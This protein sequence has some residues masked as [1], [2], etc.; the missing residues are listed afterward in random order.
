MAEM[1]ETEM[2]YTASGARRTGDEY[3]DLQS[4]EV[5]IQWL[6]QPDVYRWVRLETMEGSLDDIQ[7]EHADGARRL[8]QVKFGTDATV[9]W[10][11]DDLIK[12][13][14]GRRGPK[15]SLL[16]K[17][18]NSLDD[19]RASGA[20]VSEAALLTNRAASP[21]I[22]AHLSDSGL[23]NFDSLS[24]T[25][26]ATLSAQLGGESAA[27]LFF[28]SFHFFFK[29]RS[30]EALH[31][32]LQHR[33]QRLG[34]SREGWSSLMAAIRRW[35][36]HRDQPPPDGTITLAD[37]RAAALWHLPPPI[38]QDFLVP[39][40][41]VAPEV[42]SDATVRPRLRAGGNPLVVVTGS[43]GAGKSTYLSWLV[44]HLR[45]ENV[46]VVRH[47]YFLSLT[48][49]TSQRTA[50]EIAAEAIIGQLR[51]SYEEL[52]R[53]GNYE[54]PLPSMLRKFLVAAG[55]ER[56]EMDPLV[57][58]VDG[59]DHV[60]RDT[61]SEEALRQLFDL[62]LPVP[63]GV[64]V[65]VGTQDIDIRR[66]PLKLRNLCPP[67]QWLKVPVLDEAEVHRWLKHHAHELNLPEDEDHAKRLLS[68]L[69][70]SFFN[71]SSGHPLLLHY[72]L[73]AVRQLGPSVHPDQVGALPRFE[74]NSTIASYYRALWEGISP[75]GHLLLHLLAGFGWAWPHDGLMQCLA[76][77]ADPARL[78]QAERAVRHVLGT[79]PAGV[80]AF[81]ES[82]LAFIRAL[83]D[84]QTASDALQP[85]VMSWLTSRAPEYWRW[86]HEWE[87]RARAGD[88]APLVTSAS[89]DWCV[90]SLVAGR[91]RTEIAQVVA[92]S[93]WA[94]LA[95]GKLGVATERHYLDTYLEEARDAKGVLARLVWLALHSRDGRS[96]DLELDLFLAR[97]AQASE[98]EIEAVAEVAFSAEKFS[99]CRELFRECR[100]R[101]NA[102]VERSNRL[103][104]PFSS[105]E[106]HIPSLLAASL[107]IPSEEPYQVHV[108]EHGIEPP[109]CSTGRYAKALAR[110]CAVGGSTQALR[111]ELRFLANHAEP[112]SFEAVD[113][114]VRLACR[115]KFDPDGWI[116]N[117]EARR[118]GLFRCHRIWVRKAEEAPADTPRE[119]SFRPVWGARF[120]RDEGA[121]IELAHAY[122]FACLASAAEGRD[123]AEAVGLKI[124]ASKVEAFLATLR[125]LAIEAA[126]A[127]RAAQTVGGSWLV[128]RLATVAQ[129]KVGAND[130]D[131]YL[132]RPGPVARIV[133]AIAQDLEEL[134][135][136]ETAKW[137]LTGE[138]V[139]AAID[140]AWTSPRVWIDDRVDRR[141]G[142]G[143]RDAAQVLIDRE[144]ARLEKSRDYLH[145]RAQEYASLAQFCCLHQEAADPVRA[146]ARLAARNL[147]GHGYHKDIVL[148]DVLAA[149]RAAPRG[150]EVDTLTRLQ[151]LSPVIQV[152]E[153]ITDGD[154][155]SDLTRQLA[156]VVREVVPKALPSYLRALQHN[157]H[158]SV[159][160]SC[161]TDLAS[162]IA[163]GTVYERALASSLVHEEALTALQ[164]RAEGGDI[165]AGEVL[166]STL[167]YC[168]RQAASSRFEHPSST[169]TT[170]AINNELPSI[171]DYP[172]QRLSAFV[173]AVRDANV[174]GDEH[175]ADWTTHWR[176][177]DPDGLLAALTAYRAAHAYPHESQS[178]KMVVELALER[179]GSA[180]AWDWL[181]TY[182]K[183]R[184]GWS[185]SLYSLRDVEWIWDFVR[186]RF[187]G[188]WL[189]FITETSR[190][191]WGAAG[192]APRWSIE[193]MIRFL[194]VVREEQRVDE[195]LD[196]AVL[197]GAGLAAN[198]ELPEPALTF[199]QPDLPVAL[200]LLVDRLD[201]PS[202]MVQER[203][204]SSLA[205]LLAASDTH[206]DTAQAL[207]SWHAA[208]PLELRSCMLLLILHLARTA[209]GVSANACVAVARRANLIPSIGTDM[210]LR[211]FG[212]EGA[213]LAVSF[214]YRARHTGRPSA[215]FSGVEDFG[216]T[217][218]A[219]LAPLF[220]RWAND[221]D[222]SGIP[223]SSQWE[224]EAVGLAHHA[225]LSLRRNAHIDSHYGGIVDEPALAIND[226]LSGVLRSAYLRAMH[227]SIADAGLEVDVAE[228]HARW[229]A[230]MAEPTLW[231]VRAGTRPA[232]WP[233]DRSDADGLDTLRQAVGQAVRDRLERRDP[234]EREILL[235]AAGPVGTRPHLSGEFVI[236]AFLQSAY[237]ALKPSQEQL[238]TVPEVGCSL[239]PPR[240]FLPGTYVPA[241]QY[242]GFVREWLVAPLAWRLLPDTHEWLLPERQLRGLHLPAVWLLPDA[243]GLDT[244]THQIQIKLGEQ[245]V[246]CYRYWH[247]DLRERQYFGA[248]SR[249]GGELVVRREWLEPHLAAGATLCWVA[250][251]S[252][253]QR[254][255]YSERF[256]EPQ[257]VET[258]V[259]GGSR[260]VWPEPWRPPDVG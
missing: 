90:D 88:R 68:A 14:S 19:V 22:R 5:L 238:A 95:E 232:W 148:F 113:E 70:E 222:E 69:A 206:Q 173:R 87:V 158:H 192:G 212:D 30:F 85:R 132:V 201:C 219:H 200:R 25:L 177:H 82:L 72:T 100:R 198:M 129:L 105:L 210:L 112:A 67:D 245:P 55:R 77:Q 248:G 73:N 182:H 137:S 150:S 33:F 228:I 20:T 143:E 9:E 43:P 21:A 79:S 97:K 230:V 37:L 234:N 84:H 13:E 46:P 98:E 75:E 93:G 193:R 15:S 235:F 194:S 89:L 187:Q 149:I 3:Q 17:W 23:V 172:P 99:I 57:V 207:L 133:V 66:I 147:L 157:Y 167:A 141:L 50:W 231:A 115:D 117:A 185:W 211:E 239:S 74:P 186:T 65:V 244:D 155:T 111:E 171:Q 6:E 259:V 257:V 45:A 138:V 134:H 60:W 56:D 40:D 146:L 224:W 107:A 126:A 4:A 195:V 208:E 241:E 2:T 237:G 120:G 44:D 256:G 215:G 96:R 225:D 102:A 81:H 41:Y 246:A 162:S 205:A 116:E 240:L 53:A 35:I 159:V 223:F 63:E 122:F 229:V 39:D 242:C 123:P 253:A 203:A 202:R 58:I 190:P 181:V 188:Q 78:E 249:V 251:L 83:P 11:W 214:N 36:N 18:K 131:N 92:S 152:I 86:R 38:P 24:A 51:S 7:A 233:I 127:K 34:G 49:T 114:L 10:D 164:E 139:V 204:A 140:S 121:F 183:A 110:H 136:A 175:L 108:S 64:V 156:E 48:D 104:N 180:A 151:L 168:G 91:G 161:F 8:L 252:I 174:Y 135:Y 213:S 169:T 153:E 32:S 106:E 247:D 217:V 260:M 142:M 103:S 80:T 52:V 144:R 101:W 31:D 184:Y 118:S 179:T 255:K 145:K 166:A 250:T 226:R 47:H 130:Y 170:G 1:D 220:C 124:G 218:K 165:E 128:S 160:E 254:E 16:Q 62:L 61:G 216:L 71:V 176:S 27:G 197:W 189:K 125:G 94:A 178:A 59:L 26:K 163:L 227:W 54:N 236:R 221:L 196:S 243:P 191:L 109:W 42:W 154:E 199:E 258:W 29:E 28:E 209:H 119:V 12:Q 76:P